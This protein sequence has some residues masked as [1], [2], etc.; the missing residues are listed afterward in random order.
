[1]IVWTIW[2]LAEPECRSIK[3]HRRERSRDWIAWGTYLTAAHDSTHRARA[4]SRA[5]LR[6]VDGV[7][8][9]DPSRC[10]PSHNNRRVHPVERDY[11]EENPEGKESLTVK[12]IEPDVESWGL[13]HDN[14]TP[15][16][17]H[18]SPSAKEREPF[19]G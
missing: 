11:G 5:Q 1:M 15:T 10:V 16:R 2:N 6:A 7:D 18:S 8:K 4:S 19:H 14:N 9:A 3:T 13:R 17:K 12:V